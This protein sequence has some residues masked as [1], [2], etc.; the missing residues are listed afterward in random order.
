M[1]MTIYTCRPE[2]D[3]MMTCIYDAWASRKGHANVHLEL[4]PVEQMSLFCDYIHVEAEEEKVKKVTSSIRKKISGE[5]YR[6]IY[7]TA[8]GTDPE[9]LD[10]IYR[11]LVLGFFYGGKV[12][13]MLT[14]EP[15]MKLMELSRKAAR[16]VHFF[17]EFARFTSV[18]GQVYVSHIEPK[19]DVIVSVAEHFADRMP[20]EHFIMIDDTRKKAVI[21]P[22]DEDFYVRIL[23][24][25]EY[26]KLRQA[27][28]LEDDF[29]A[30]WRQYFES[31]AIEARKNP[32][33]QM[34]M[35]PL[36]YRKHATEF[37]KKE[38]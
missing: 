4:E 30:L 22:K 27:E 38:S 33:C 34:N 10:V 6:Q 19:S 1:S 26:E 20:S 13:N 32:K 3:D 16:E 14:E 7:Y 5:A 25:E 21:H 12:V 31:I 11:F 37:M 2:F 18:N 17:H 15:V 28:F 9:R 8:I 36:W 35:M 24:E 29:T 23:T